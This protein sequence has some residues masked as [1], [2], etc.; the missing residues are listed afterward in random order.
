M[1]NIRKEQPADYAAVY[2][3]VKQAFEHAEHTDHNEPNLVNRL[4][5]SPFYLP[6][7]ALVAETGGI[8]VG[9]IMFTETRGGDSR[10]LLLAPLSV[11]PQ[12]QNCG[13]GSALIKEGHRKAKELGYEYCFLVGHVGYVRAS[14]LGVT[15]SLEFPDENFMG[16]D[17][18]GGRRLLNAELI[19]A[20]VFLD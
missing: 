13:I 12:Y 14:A 17:L 5:Q 6:E 11:L 10:Q 7:L 1:I 20:P 3:L 18:Q 9:H 4:R 16:I 8:I 15:C 19:L 2:E